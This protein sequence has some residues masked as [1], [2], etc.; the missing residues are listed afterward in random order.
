MSQLPL[1]IDD[2]GHG[3]ISYPV[4]LQIDG[5]TSYSFVLEADSGVPRLEFGR[6][7]EETNDFAVLGVRGHSVPGS[8]RQGW[9]GGFDDRM[10]PLAQGAIRFRHR[11]DRREHFAFPVGL[12]RTWTA[13]RIRLQ[14]PGSLLHCPSLLI[15][16]SAGRLPDRGCAPGGL[17]RRGRAVP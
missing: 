2:T 16:E 11:G 7:L 9:R 17:P 8:G 4:P 6:A 13:A 12:L 15:R 10:E 5:V 3:S 1:Y 14:F